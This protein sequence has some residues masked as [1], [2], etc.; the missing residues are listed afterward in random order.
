MEYSY[1]KSIDPQQD[2]DC[3]SWG[4]E[5]APANHIGFIAYLVKAKHEL[6]ERVK[7]LESK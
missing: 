7:A 1:P 6:H 4:K 2:P 5:A 3:S